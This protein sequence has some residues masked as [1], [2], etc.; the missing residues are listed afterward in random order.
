[1]LAHGMEAA[2]ELDIGVIAVPVTHPHALT[3]NGAEPVLAAGEHEALGNQLNAL[4]NA[5][6][7]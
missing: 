3:R 5:S 2:F 1:M 6:R 7:R 4:A